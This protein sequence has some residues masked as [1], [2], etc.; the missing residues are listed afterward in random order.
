MTL[1][2]VCFAMVA[3]AH[4]SAAAVIQEGDMG[5]EVSEVQSK[6]GALGYSAGPADGDFGASTAAA[7]KAFQKDR[8]LEADG[9]IG[10][11]T[12]RAL[13]GRDIPA[14]RGGSTAAVRRVVDTAMRYV[15]VPYSFGGTTPDG[16]D[17][18]GFVRFVFARSGVDLPRMADE[19]YELGQS[20]SMGRLQPGDTVYFST[21]TSGISHVGIYLGDGRFI[22]ASSSRGV[23]IDRLDSGYWGSRYMGARRFL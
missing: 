17:C 23:V 9:V 8:G 3:F 15:G 21:Y 14:S 1:F 16:F 12:Y 2:V 4:A 13:M 5:Q 10:P 6:L 7:V 22:S 18:S 19:Q 11:S 20:V